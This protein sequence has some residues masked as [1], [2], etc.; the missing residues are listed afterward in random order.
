M[1][2]IARNPVRKKTTIVRRVSQKERRTASNDRLLA[3]G[4][5]LISERGSGGMSL[6]DVG[7]AAGYSRGLP[8]E[9]FGS[10]AGFLQA[11]VE[12]LQEWIDARISTALA[13]KSGLE[14]VLARIECHIEAA[15]ENPQF[16]RA[17]Y[18]LVIESTWTEPDL[19]A[20][21]SKLER[22]HRQGFIK[23]LKEGQE[24]GEIKATLDLSQQAI[25]IVGTMR[26][27]IIQALVGA[28]PGMLS[29]I[30]GDVIQM[31]RLTLKK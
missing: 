31:F 9:R 18:H 14:A 15:E 7:L 16:H 25:I 21:I 4:L 26:G 1:S 12:F 20:A 29:K 13:D 22:S 8:G 2:T 5:K 17:L 6:A 19:H 23:L 24:R 28:T 3:A 10:K 27:V 30:K 11:L